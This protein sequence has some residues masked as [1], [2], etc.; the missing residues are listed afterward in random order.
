MAF[1]FQIQA[2]LSLKNARFPQFSFRIL[3]AL[4]KICL[5][6]IDIN[7]AKPWANASSKPNISDHRPDILE[8]MRRNKRTHRP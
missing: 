7:V 8:R 5:F 4:A 2:Q 3:I 1:S 6:H